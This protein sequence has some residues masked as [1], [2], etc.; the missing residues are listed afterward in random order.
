[1]QADVSNGR[2]NCT[3]SLI[4]SVPQE[5]D[6]SLLWLFIVRHFPFPTDKQTNPHTES[7]TVVHVKC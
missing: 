4:W 1:M 2:K 7:R 5:R 3:L 6:V